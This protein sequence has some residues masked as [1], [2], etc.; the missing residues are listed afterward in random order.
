MNKDPEF[1]FNGDLPDLSNV[2]TATAHV[3]CGQ[4]TFTFCKAPIRLDLPEGGGDVWYDR[5]EYCAVDAT[6][7]DSTPSLAVAYL[8]AEAGEG[9]PTIDNRPKDQS[10]G[11]G[12]QR[13]R[14]SRRCGCSVAPSA[15]ASMLVLLAR[16][17]GRARPTSQADLTA[18]DPPRYLRRLP[19][20][21]KT[22][23]TQPFPPPALRFFGRS[24][25]LTPTL[26]F[27]I[28]ACGAGPKQSLGPAPGLTAP[29]LSPP[30]RRP[31]RPRRRL[32]T[33]A[34]SARRSI[35]TPTASTPASSATAV[36]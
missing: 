27:L 36:W 23:E 20:P 12:A 16:A 7:F 4:Q 2:H 22:V 35:C 21:T 11:R 14:Q 34:A 28:A 5:N 30:R 9:Q 31:R 33:P 32:S 13:H 1:V 24:P 17:G 6:T 19:H 10:G 8:R 3:M 26:A 29:S 18:R 25:R 15:S